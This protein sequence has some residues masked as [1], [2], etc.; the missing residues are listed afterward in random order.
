MEYR[1]YNSVEAFKSA[2]YEVLLEDEAQNNL[3][4]SLIADSNVRF[5]SDWLMA[6]IHGDSGD[7][8]LIAICTKPFN[9]L[10]YE[11][12]GTRQD[13]AAELVARELLKSG[14]D[15]EGVTAERGLARR[16]AGAFC[17]KGGFHRLH[18]TMNIMRLDKLKDCK[19]A[20][21]FY[22][23]LEA[24]DI[25]FAPY[26]ERAFSEEC[27]VPALTI[28]ENTERLYNRIGKNTHYIWENGVPVSQAV[29]GRD[30]PNGAVINSVYTPPFYRGHGYATS[31]VATLSK[32]LLEHGKSFCCLY[33][34]ADNP[35]SCSVYRKLGYNNVCTLED[36]K[37][38]NGR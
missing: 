29:Y 7:I 21:G 3:L 27:R 31:I 8:E 5:A 1:H 36:I 28:P 35:I 19:H 20:P 34:D 26:W 10:L 13:G 12:A 30:T 15:P 38:D 4:I 33:A 14:F 24:R 17:Y 37:F 2:V 11:P 9:L 18:M 16:F 6:A 32:N 22:R 23:T 25:F